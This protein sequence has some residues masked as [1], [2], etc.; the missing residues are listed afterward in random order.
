MIKKQKNQNYE[1]ELA[2]IKEIRDNSAILNDHSILC[3]HKIA[4][5]NFKKISKTKKDKIT[6]EYNNWLE[7]LDFPVQIIGRNVNYNMEKITE[8]LLNNLEI[9]LKKKEEVREYLK[10]YENFRDWLRKFIKNNNKTKRVYY[11]VIPFI[12][13][14]SASLINPFKYKKQSE[15]IFQR[16]LTLLN[17]RANNCITLLEKTGVKT[18]RLENHQIK[19][20]IQSYLKPCIYTKKY[21]SPEKLFSMWKKET[22]ETDA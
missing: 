18:S 1:S 10:H 9:E 15:E 8:I 22:G 12:D 7:S 2:N 5:I 11:L 6:K 14:T 17:K 4:P 20:L 16:K 13:T 21:L 3:I 19:N